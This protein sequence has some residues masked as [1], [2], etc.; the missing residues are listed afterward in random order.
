MVTLVLLRV[1]AVI[2][3]V[4]T[5][6]FFVAAE[7]ALVSIRDTRLQQLIDDKRLG[8]RTILKLHQNL[9]E[10]LAAVQLGVTL[11]SLGLGWIGEATIAD[12]LMRVFAHIPYIKIYAH[13]VGIV[14][15]FVLI[16]YVVVILGEVVP[17]TIALQ[18]ADRVALAVAGPMDVFVTIGRPFLRLLSKSASLVLRAFGSRQLREGNVHSPEELKLM[19]TASRRLGMLPEI[20]EDMIHRALELGN[21]TV[22]EIMVP[23]PQIF[24]LSAEMPVEE[25]VPRVV[26]QQYSRIPVYDPQQGPE[27]IVGV[28][29][30]KDLT[31]LM[32]A[33]MNA[34]GLP[35]VLR[36]S[37]KLRHIMRDVLVVPETKAI[38]DLLVDFKKHR[39]HLAVVVD[40][41]GTTAGVVSV[42]DVLE[43]IVGEIEDE[44]DTQREPP[45]RIGK[46]PVVLDGAQNIRDLDLQY[47]LELPRDQGFE[48][49]GG[50]VLSRLQRIPRGGEHFDYQGRRYTVLA[51]D[52][53][54]V[55]AVKIEPVEAA[56]VTTMAKKPD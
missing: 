51:M 25:A 37:T 26:E 6:A 52:G 7:F 19:V 13:G 49:L 50:F 40:E 47:D 23:R 45:T 54:R 41:F 42:E 3:L 44:F 43:Q 16:T 29:Y 4:A 24:S 33:S 38:S 56:P 18:R 48:T 12:L 22:R 20:Q 10:L 35:E 46:A 8:A 17:K 53:R 30:S 28:L 9:D 5:N 21:I 34:G 1:A 39:R 2:L 32:Y 14:F 15:G 36:G 55:G 11:A 27:Q 31:R